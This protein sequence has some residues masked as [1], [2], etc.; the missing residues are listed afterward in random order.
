MC[1]RGRSGSP[2]PGPA[3]PRGHGHR[4]YLRAARYV[5]GAGAAVGSWARCFDVHRGQ[6]SPWQRL[7][8]DPHRLM[9]RYRAGYEHGPL[10]QLGERR[11]RRVVQ[12]G[13]GLRSRPRMEHLLQRP[14]ATQ[15]VAQQGYHGLRRR[16][17]GRVHVVRLPAALGAAPR[18]LRQADAGYPGSQH[19]AA[20]PQGPVVSRVPAVREHRRPSAP[21]KSCRRDRECDDT[22]LRGLEPGI[23]RC[24]LAIGDRFGRGT[25][26]GAS[27]RFADNQPPPCD[28]R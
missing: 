9:V 8:R 27:V 22:C 15:S 5:P 11:S 3:A 7:H 2:L 1:A 24:Q 12:R 21:T 18:R 23:P 10:P 20:H 26:A 4:G 28:I 19:L 25:H 17:R 14:P 6:H 13:R 16:N